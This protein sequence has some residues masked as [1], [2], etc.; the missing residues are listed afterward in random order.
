MTQKTCKE[1]RSSPRLP[2]QTENQRMLLFIDSPH[3]SST[4]DARTNFKNV[5][6]AAV[7]FD[8]AAHPER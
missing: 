5:L 4:S 2:G 6:D 8:Q 7:L 3:Y 1:Q